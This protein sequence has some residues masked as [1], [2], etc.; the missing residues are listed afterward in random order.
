VT[1]KKPQRIAT[2][3]AAILAGRPAERLSEQQRALFEQVAVS[4]PAL[5]WMRNLAMDFRE[6]LSSKDR[7]GLLNWIQ[8]AARSGVGPAVRFASGLKKDLGAAA[9]TPWSNGQS[10]GQINRLKPSSAKCI[11][12]PDPICYEHASFLTMPCRHELHRKC[13]RF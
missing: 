6:A 8:M 13:G 4:C 5:H 12:A 9:E 7:A 11:A 2:K 1:N 10:E 3:R